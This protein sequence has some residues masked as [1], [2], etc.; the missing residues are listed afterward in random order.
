MNRNERRQTRTESIRD[1][2]RE[3]RRGDLQSGVEMLRD[4][5]SGASAPGEPGL[6]II[7]EHMLGEIGRLVRGRRL[8]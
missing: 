8:T 2:L 6:T 5:R 4:V 7:E 1:T 3:V